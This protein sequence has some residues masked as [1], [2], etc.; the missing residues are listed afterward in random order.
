MNQHIDCYLD[1]SVD[2]FAGTTGE[3][4]HQ[5]GDSRA[6]FQRTVLQGKCLETTTDNV[7]TR[8]GEVVV[9]QRLTA[10]ATQQGQLMTTLKDV[11]GGASGGKSDD[12]G[13]D[14]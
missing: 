8:G 12:I 9:D 13:N 2:G 5:F 10:A 1:G 4:Q 3:F 7:R 14:P 11:V 6:I